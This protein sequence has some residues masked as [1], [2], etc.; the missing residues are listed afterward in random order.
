MKT[1][2]QITALAAELTEA[3]VAAIIRAKAPKNI[4]GYAVGSVWLHDVA[5][6]DGGFI[7]VTLFADN[8]NA[9]G[10]TFEEASDKLARL[11]AR[12]VAA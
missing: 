12:P 10:R 11:I 9:S 8:A 4:N 2:N 5:C 1:P 6:V 3:D 7:D